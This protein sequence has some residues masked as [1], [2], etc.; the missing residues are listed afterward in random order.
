MPVEVIKYKCQHRCGF[1]AVS[2]KRV[3]AR[4]EMMCWKNPATKS[5]T[6]CKHEVYY[7]DG[8]DHD[9]LPGSPSEKW[10]VRACN[11]LTE[12]GLS[13]MINESG[14]KTLQGFHIP[15]AKNCPYWVSRDQNPEVSDTTKKPNDQ[16]WKT[17]TNTMENDIGCYDYYDP[18]PATDSEG[19]ESPDELNNL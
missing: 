19:A 13:E 4:H 7:M 6:T 14:Y 2:D 8:V 3:A 17:K 9:E 1:K 15:P 11:L 10:M 16:Y 5:C 12:V 18:R